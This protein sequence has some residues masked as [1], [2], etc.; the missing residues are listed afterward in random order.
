VG[1]VGFVGIFCLMVLLLRFTGLLIMILAI[2]GTLL[3]L[4]VLSAC[5]LVVLLVSRFVVGLL[6]VGVRCDCCF[7]C[8]C[9]PY[10]FV[11]CFGG[12]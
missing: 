1:I 4:V 3:A 5:G 12:R 7:L 9:S 6:R 2:W 8:L 11:A 10:W